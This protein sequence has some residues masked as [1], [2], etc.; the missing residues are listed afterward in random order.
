MEGSYTRMK[1]F[2]SRFT[3]SRQTTLVDCS[4]GKSNNRLIGCTFIQSMLNHLFNYLISCLIGY[5]PPPTLQVLQQSKS[6]HDEACYGLM[7]ETAF[8]SIDRNTC[9]SVIGLFLDKQEKLLA[10]SRF[11]RK[12]SSRFY[13][14]RYEN[15][16]R[17]CLRP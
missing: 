3:N 9:S 8:K 15:W 16:V 11:Y 17:M 14:K 7:E 10:G 4:I 1:M 2:P 5:E 12:T 6:S 13:M